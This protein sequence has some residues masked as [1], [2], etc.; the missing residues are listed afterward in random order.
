[1]RLIKRF[2][3]TIQYWNEIDGGLLAAAVSFYAS[4]SIFPLMMILLAGFGYFLRFTGQGQD[5]QSQVLKYV[6]DQS[7][8]KLADQISTFLGQIESSSFFNG[9][10][11]LIFLLM[12]AM[13]MFVN[14]ER[15]FA[16]IWR[17]KTEPIGIWKNTKRILLHRF[18]AFAMLLVVAMLVIVN[19]LSNMTIDVVAQFVGDF[20]LSQG[21]WRAV[22]SGSAILINTVL[23]GIINLTLPSVSV[24]W[25]KALQGG[26]FTAITWEMGRYIL[27]WM[28]ISDKYNAFGVVG[29]FMGLLLWMFYASSAI[30]LGAVF[31]RVADNKSKDESNE[32]ATDQTENTEESKVDG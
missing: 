29:V 20:Y 31:V 16:R 11:G 5:L 17:T 13:A 7:T 18:R 3:R 1:M 14:F 9:P 6:A 26:L 28:V 22:Q 12:L 32:Q 15:A 21:W 25:T 27:A 19:F 30:L 4:L 8:P 24:R 10:L 23:F 2:W